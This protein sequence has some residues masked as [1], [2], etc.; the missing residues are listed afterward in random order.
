M[1]MLL[2]LFV[3][4]DGTWAKSGFTSLIGV[5]FVISV[6]TGEVLDYQIV[7]K[8]CQ[9]CSIRKA[10]FGEDSEA[11]GEWRMEHVASE[12]WDIYFEGI[13]RNWG[14]LEPVVITSGMPCDRRD[15]RRS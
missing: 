11:F 14:H 15:Q 13:V 3:S 4:F 10:Q 6:E 5:V 9:Q 7:S 1:M 8:E 12:E 2:I